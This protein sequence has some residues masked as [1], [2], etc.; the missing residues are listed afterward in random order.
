MNTK[1]YQVVV[2][3]DVTEQVWVRMVPEL[4]DLSTF[5]ET[6]EEIV[7]YLEVIEKEGLPVPSNV[8]DVEV[9]D[10]EVATA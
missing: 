1:Q 9:V 7:G 2:E 6:R 3:W 8:H 4:D 5:G 10:L